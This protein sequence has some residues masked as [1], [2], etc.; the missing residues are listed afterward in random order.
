MSLVQQQQLDDA[1][2]R[3]PD[4]DSLLPAHAQAVYQAWRTL[5]VRDAQVASYASPI[6]LA[7]GRMRKD[8]RCRLLTLSRTPF[9]PSTPSPPPLLTAQ[10]VLDFGDPPAGGE[11]NQEVDDGSP[12]EEIIRQLQ[13]QLQAQKTAI[14]RLL[15]QQESLADDTPAHNTYP[16]VDTTL[17]RLPRSIRNLV[18]MS[19]VDRRKLRREHSGLFP[20]DALP[21]ELQIPEDIRKEKSVQSAKIGFLA[22]TKEIIQPAMDANTDSLKMAA[23]IHS[24]LEE[25]RAE[26]ADAA[27]SDRKASVLAADILEEIVTIIGT[28]EGTLDMVLD[29]HARLR[30]A[31][32]SRLEKLMG[33]ENLHQDP[34]KREK[35]SFLSEDFDRKIEER[36]KAKAHLAWARNQS[37]ATNLSRGSLHE[38]PPSKSLGGGG[39]A[40]RGRGRGSNQDRGKGRGKGGKGDRSSSAK[41]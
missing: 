32:T 27:N 12:Q 39:T 17:Q 3:W 38:N 24:R 16:I 13:I 35:E 6:P 4:D 25:L 11:P 37:R 23:T 15:V 19:R 29:T 5:R 21:R 10:Q 9:P 1:V 31:V 22:V 34:N 36:A 8:D 28:T 18:P 2:G 26:L 41:P 20:K 7:T 14:D 33:F 40:S 30:T